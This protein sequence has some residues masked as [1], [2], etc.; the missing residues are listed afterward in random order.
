MT[1]SGK[2]TVGLA[3]HVHTTA[4]LS[5]AVPEGLEGSRHALVEDK[6]CVQVH[7]LLPAVML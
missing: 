7:I 2:V 5:E 3:A 1:V 6:V 4:D